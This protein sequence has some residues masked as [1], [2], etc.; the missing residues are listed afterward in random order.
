[1]S[2]STQ[3]MQSLIGREIWRTFRQP[4]R[5]A[6]TLGLPI[7]LWIVAGAGLAESFSMPTGGA[8]AGISYARFVLPGMMLCVIILGAIFCAAALVQDRRDGFLKSVLA[9]PAPRAHIVGAK[10]ISGAIIT[11]IQA[12]ILLGGSL[13]IGLDP[14]PV[15]FVLAILAMALSATAIV[16]AC[17]TLA[18]WYNAKKGFGALMAAIFLPLWLLS[19]ALFPI[20]GAEGWLRMAMR[21]NPVHWCQTCLRSAL[22][23]GG[24][25]WIYWIGLAAFAGGMYF[26]ALRVMGSMRVGSSRTFAPL[27]GMTMS[28]GE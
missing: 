25:G 3:A 2:V 10:V 26:L 19:G 22:E 21:A 28:R 4:T 15:G 13:W 9:S 12:G 24:G 16:S 27:P 18:W 7:G 23:L 6:A 14:G 8:D 5:L 1:M 20:E 17:L 11:G